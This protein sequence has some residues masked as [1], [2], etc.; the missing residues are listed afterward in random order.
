MGSQFQS[1]KEDEVVW[2]VGCLLRGLCPH[3]WR[4]NPIP[5]LSAKSCQ[6]VTAMNALGL[7][8]NAKRTEKLAADL[9]GAMELQHHTTA[10]TIAAHVGEDHA[11]AME[12]HAAKVL[13]AKV[14]EFVHHK[15]QQRTKSLWAAAEPSKWRFI[16]I[17]S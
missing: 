15:Q 11:E 2:S 6:F 1:A 5:N 17:P 8:R 10:K 9:C 12:K 3:R 14:M 16:V 13:L 7:E 4:P